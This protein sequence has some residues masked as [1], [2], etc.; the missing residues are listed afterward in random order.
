MSMRKRFPTAK[1]RPATAA[2]ELAVLSPLLCLLFVV[3]VDYAR[4]F[5]FT[6]VVTNCARSG[7]IYGMKN[8]TAANDQTGISDAAKKD[9]G[10][11]NAVNLTVTSSTDSGTNPSYVIVTVTY[12]FATISNF[13]GIAGTTTISRTIQMAVTPLTPG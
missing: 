5:H 6:M 12:P 2:V 9:A 8:S 10:N 7:A 1:S 3:A 13:P 4:I 11:L